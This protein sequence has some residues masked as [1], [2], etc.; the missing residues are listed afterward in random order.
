MASPNAGKNKLARH[1]RL[2]HGGVDLSGD[3]REFQQLLWG[4]EPV[5]LTGWAESMRNYLPDRR[6]NAGIVGFSAFVNDATGGAFTRLKAPGTKKAVALFFGGG[7]S[8]VAGD[9]AYLLQTVQTMH[10]MTWNQQAGVISGSFFADSANVGGANN[11]FGYV[12]MPLTTISD[13]TY[14]TAVDLEAAGT[15][16]SACIQICGTSS[17]NYAFRVEQDSAG[18][19]SGGETTL[20]TFAVNGSSIS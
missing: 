17:G 19:F 1:V 2:Y 3:A 7:A 9:I 11:P 15:G 6:M 16:Y 5:D 8:P 4:Y 13:T 14:G 10:D 12:L 18:T 20:C